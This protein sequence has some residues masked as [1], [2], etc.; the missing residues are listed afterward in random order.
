MPRRIT[1]GNID[2]QDILG[3]DFI[4]DSTYVDASSNAVSAG[5]A[6]DGNPATAWNST[7]DTSNWWAFA[8]DTAGIN[9]VVQTIH[10]ECITSGDAVV[11]AYGSDSGSLEGATALVA[12]NGGDAINGSYNDSVSFECTTV[13]NYIIIVS[14]GASHT[15]TITNIEMYEEHLLENGYSLFWNETLNK[16]TTVKHYSTVQVDSDL[17]TLR[18]NMFLTFFKSG[19]AYLPVVDG[20]C[21]SFLDATGIDVGNSNGYAAYSGYVS[22]LALLEEHGFIYHAEGYLRERSYQYP[23][24]DVSDVEKRV[25]T[26]FVVTNSQVVT[27]VK[28]RASGNISPLGSPTGTIAVRIE[29]DSTGNPSGTLAHANAENVFAPATAVYGTE[30]PGRG[31]GALVSFSPFTLAAG[32]YWLTLRCDAQAT[33]NCWYMAGHKSAGWG[34]VTEDVSVMRYSDDGGSTWTTPGAGTMGL[35]YYELQNT[36]IVS[37]MVLTSIAAEADF[38]PA[39]AR[40]LLLVRPNEAVTWNVDL[41]CDVSLDSG[42]NWDVIT[43][44]QKTIM[45]DASTYV[46]WGECYLTDRSDKTMRLRIR[47]GNSKDIDIVGT[48]LGW[49][50]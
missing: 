21:D 16:F 44:Q 50:L 29:T 25:A 3:A 34:W 27:G 45:Y 31:G 33:N 19:L 43:L 26:K 17:N 38:E 49:A 47:T 7:S 41:F 13:Y 2:N 30:T 4:Q 37:D 15:L 11:A 14:Q 5:N 23:I 40:V 10:L 39:R 22:S 8:N 12:F 9:K 24:G 36:G 1:I 48:A 28:I 46:L 42:A 18:D 32:T 20:V 6:N 35:M